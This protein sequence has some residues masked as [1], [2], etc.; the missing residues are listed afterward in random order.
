MTSRPNGDAS[1]SSSD[2]VNPPIGDMD[3]HQSA[4]HAAMVW[5]FQME[6]FV[7]DD[8]VLKPGILLI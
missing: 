4:E 8:E 7:N 5:D 3:A 1:R 6:K 2:I